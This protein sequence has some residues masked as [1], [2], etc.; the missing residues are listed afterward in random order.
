VELILSKKSDKKTLL[1]K[2]NNKKGLCRCGSSLDEERFKTCSKC[3]EY[4]RNRRY[5]H[6]DYAEKNK[7]CYIMSCNNP[8]DVNLK[9]VS[10]EPCR[11]RRI[12]TYQC[13]INSNLCVVCKSPAAIGKACCQLHLSYNIKSQKKSYIRKK[14]IKRCIN[15][16]GSDLSRNTLRCAACNLKISNNWIKTKKDRIAKGLCPCGVNKHNKN[17]YYCSRCLKKHNNN[18]RASKRSVRIQLE[19]LREVESLLKGI[20]ELDENYIYKSDAK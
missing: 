18:S 10:C 20:M 11:T 14:K 1:R 6:E 12:N 15:C 17:N 16:G 13:R 19:E 4:E 9:F 5:K 8:I 3:R 7:L 2:N